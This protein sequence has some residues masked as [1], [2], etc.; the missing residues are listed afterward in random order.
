MEQLYPRLADS[1]LVL[2]D[3]RD[4][5]ARKRAHRERAAWGRRWTDYYCLDQ[6]H[7]ILAFRP[8]SAVEASA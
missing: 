4:P 2:Y 6:D 8:G 1:T 5:A 3:L 7:V